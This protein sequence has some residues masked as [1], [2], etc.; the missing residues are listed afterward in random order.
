MFVFL[1]LQRLTVT[2][3]CCFS[4]HA[5]LSV[6]LNIQY[7]S[8]L[9]LGSDPVDEMNGNPDQLR[10]QQFNADVNVLPEVCPQLGL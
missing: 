9:S 8:L 6:T 1:G 5:H 4:I 10:I 2:D 7:S 3:I